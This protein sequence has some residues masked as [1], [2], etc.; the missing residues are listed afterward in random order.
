MSAEDSAMAN[1]EDGRPD[2][3]IKHDKADG[4]L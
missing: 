1:V 2:E 4:G 3:T